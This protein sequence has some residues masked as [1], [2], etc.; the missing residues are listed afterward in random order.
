MNLVTSELA[1]HMKI[2]DAFRELPA[3][4]KRLI[5]TFYVS[6]CPSNLCRFCQWSVVPPYW[7]IQPICYHCFCPHFLPGS[8]KRV[9]YPL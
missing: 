1:E 5:Q 7:S 6:T 3:D 9:C 4:L 2:L 8:K